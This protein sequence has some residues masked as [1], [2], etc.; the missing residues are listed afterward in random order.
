MHYDEDEDVYGQ[1]H[2]AEGQEFEV[3]HD[4]GLEGFEV[5]FVIALLAAIA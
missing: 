3:G 5:G 4:A 2:C 1:D